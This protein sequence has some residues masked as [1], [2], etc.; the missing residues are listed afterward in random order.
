MFEQVNPTCCTAS[1][2]RPIDEITFTYPDGTV[3]RP[4][5]KDL[6]SHIPRGTIY[7]QLTGSGSG[8]GDPPHRDP[9]RIAQD[10]LTP[11]RAPADN[12]F[13]SD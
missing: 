2:T 7:R 6:V 10:V 3:L 9:E 12:W 11:E 5:L 1:S 4:R 13:E 8:S